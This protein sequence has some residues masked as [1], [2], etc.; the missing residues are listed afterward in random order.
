MT[1]RKFPEKP[2]QMQDLILREAITEEAACVA[3]SSLL[4]PN[5]IFLLVEEPVRARRPS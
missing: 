1:I 2:L 4:P 5:T 3:V